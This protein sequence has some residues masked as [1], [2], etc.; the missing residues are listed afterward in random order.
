[1]RSLTDDS[2]E[3]RAWAL[4]GS[5]RISSASLISPVFFSLSHLAWIIRRQG[6]TRVSE[7][8]QVI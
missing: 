5:T 3:M 7:R 1:M 8:G 6:G 4:V 2:C